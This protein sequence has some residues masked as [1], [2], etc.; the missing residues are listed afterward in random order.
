M[1]R[2]AKGAPLFKLNEAGT[3]YS[4]AGVAEKTLNVKL[5]SFKPY[6]LEVT[7]EHDGTRYR[8]AREFVSAAPELHP[9]DKTIDRGA[10]GAAGG[11]IDT[12]GAELNDEN[13]TDLADLDKKDR[14]G[15]EGTPDPENEGSYPGDGETNPPT[16]E[17]S[18]EESEDDS[19]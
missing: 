3:S 12:Q 9:D 15:A 7:F 19:E 18:E 2:V 17:D 5:V 11:A 8:V 10:L 14:E 13:T 1:A 6:D 16:N 4:A